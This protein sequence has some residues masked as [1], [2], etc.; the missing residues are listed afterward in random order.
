VPVA[1][2]IEAFFADNKEL[3]DKHGIR[4]SYLTCFSGA[5]FLIEPSFYWYDQLG[6]YRMSRIEPEFQ[7]KW[8]D[9]EPDQETREVVLGLRK[10]IRDI[11]F[12]HGAC[13]LQIGKYYPYEDAMVGG[14]GEPYWNLLKDIKGLIDPDKRINPGSLGL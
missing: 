6:P 9:R 10:G 8:Q 3:M 7:E 2:E 5:E 12:K 1:Q 11:F 13:H 4:T 14:P